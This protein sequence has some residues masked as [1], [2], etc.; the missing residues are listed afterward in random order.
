MIHTEHS[1]FIHAI[2]LL[3]LFLCI[4]IAG[5]IFK[6][7]AGVIVPVVIAV[8]LA[9]VLEPV[10]RKLNT[11]VKIP[12]LLA[13]IIVLMALVVLI[14]VLANMFVSGITAIVNLYPKYEERFTK[15][16]ATL[17]LQ[18]HLPFDN[19]LSLFSNLWSSL[20]VR[21]AIQNTAI[22]ISGN[23]ISFSKN[24]VMVLFF[25]FFLL[26]EAR[27]MKRK[28]QNPVFQKGNTNIEIAIK[29]IMKQ[30]THYI[31]IKAFV[32]LL[33]GFLVFLGCA[34]AGLQFP[35]IWGLLAFILNFIPNFGSIISG[36]LTTL[37]A[38]VQFYPSWERT[39]FIIILM[40]GV[41]I[42]IGYVVEPKWEGKGLGL[43]PFF[44]I[45]SLSLWG[46]LWGF[47][48]LVLAVPMT[49]IMKIV[50]EN[51]PPLRPFAVLMGSE[52]FSRDFLSFFNSALR[53]RPAFALVLSRH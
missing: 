4:V 25:V 39:V 7:M 20:G 26:A 23:L 52:S 31:T 51:I 36:L 9:F 14:S 30:V 35:I 33:T 34:I 19:E 12:W 16:Y 43:S 1:S 15:I 32:S 46:W 22:S 42:S 2:F 27:S 3:L 8:L 45:V 48:G 13:E 11:I 21:T 50:C 6:L 47:A 37:F 17:A 49:V 28:L 53:K 5:T 38:V 44:I 41:N 40:I 24:A 10:I 18:F 29:D